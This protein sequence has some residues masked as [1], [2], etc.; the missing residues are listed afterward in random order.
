MISAEEADLLY[1]SAAR[2]ATGVIVEV[3]SYRGRSTVALAL[4]TRAGHGRPVYAVDPHEP[5]TGVLGGQFGPE[6]RGAFYRAM[7]TT[8]CYRDVR[9]INLASSVVAPNWNQAVGL[10]WIDGDHTLVGVTADFS[11][12]RSHLTPDALVIF[13]DAVDP[14]IGPYQL[15]EG[16]LANGEVDE[17]DG[18]GKI[19]TVRLRRS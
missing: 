3:G 4:G 19:R 7:L 18:S 2:V 14:A 13:D 16:L 8:G 9:L 17:M 15:L 10:L 11:A 6:D 1:R 5:F 12:W